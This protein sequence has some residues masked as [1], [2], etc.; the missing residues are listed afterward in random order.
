MFV[1]C[2]RGLFARGDSARGAN[3]GASAA[4]Y[5]DVG[6]D[7]VLLAFGDSTSGA[8]VKA[9]AA[10]NTIVAN[11]VSHGCRILRVNNWN[12]VGIYCPWGQIVATKLRISTKRGTSFAV[13]FA[14]SS[15]YLRPLPPISYFCSGRQPL[16]CALGRASL[17]NISAVL[18][19]NKGRFYKLACDGF[20]TIVP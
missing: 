18:A 9:S 12:V 10:S 20:L 13:F 4:I 14:K 2:C 1:I 19:F 17:C 15:K 3:V 6:V 8:V 11:Y 7:G 16:S 5:T